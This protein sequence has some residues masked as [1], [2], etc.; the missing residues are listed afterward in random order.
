MTRISAI[1][2][3]DR[4]LPSPTPEIEQERRVAVFDLL[5][6]NSF[7]IPGRHG[8]PAPEGPF[9]L[10]LA[11]REGKLVFDVTSED[12]VHHMV[13]QG[14]QRFRVLQFL[15]GYPFLV[16]RVAPVETPEKR[17]SVSTATVLPQGI[18]L[19]ADVT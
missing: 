18:N 1:E 19:S 7:S 3:D 17:A 12:G 14:T 2:I 6:D 13:C 15:E 5:E 4:G 9:R 10:S 8:Q 16:A 11:I